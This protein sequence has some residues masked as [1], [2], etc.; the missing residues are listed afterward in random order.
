M[1][2]N[3]GPPQNNNQNNIFTSFSNLSYDSGLHTLQECDDFP[4][5]QI[6]DND[7]QNTNFNLFQTNPPFDLDFNVPPGFDNIQPNN[8][9][10]QNEPQNQHTNSNSQLQKPQDMKKHFQDLQEERKK[11]IN[12]YPTQS[13]HDYFEE[14]KTTNKDEII[15]ETETFYPVFVWRDKS[16][17]TIGISTK[18]QE[19]LKTDKRGQ[20]IKIQIVTKK[21][22]K[23]EEQLWCKFKIK[24]DH[25]M[26]K[27]LKANITGTNSNTNNSLKRKRGNVSTPP[28]KRPAGN[29]SNNCFLFRINIKN[30]EIKD[31]VPLNNG[32]GIC[33]FHEGNIEKIGVINENRVDVYDQELKFERSICKS[34]EGYP[35][36]VSFHDDQFFVTNKNYYSIFNLNPNDLTKDSGH[37]KPYTQIPFQRTIHKK[38]KLHYILL[39]DYFVCNLKNLE[40]PMFIVLFT[41]PQITSKFSDFVMID[42]YSALIVVSGSTTK[43][44][45]QYNI[46]SNNENFST[47]QFREL[48]EPRSFQNF[49]DY[50]CNEHKAVGKLSP[51]AINGGEL[52]TNGLEKPHGI[53]VWKN[54]IL[55]SV[56]NGITFVDKTNFIKSKEIFLSYSPGKLATTE[57]YI[58]TI[59]SPSSMDEN[60]SSREIKDISVDKPKRESC[61]LNP[62]IVRKLFGKSQ[63]DNTFDVRDNI[64]C[65]K[66]LFSSVLITSPFLQHLKEELDDIDNLVLL[67]NDEMVR[68]TLK[69]IFRTKFLSFNWNRMCFWFKVLNLKYIHDHKINAHISMNLQT[70]NKN[71]NFE[72]LGSIVFIDSEWK[73]SYLNKNNENPPFSI[74][75]ICEENEETIHLHHERNDDKN[76]DVTSISIFGCTLVRVFVPTKYKSIDKRGMFV[77]VNSHCT[78][79]DNIGVGEIIS[80]GDLHLRDSDSYHIVGCC[81][82]DDFSNI[83]LCS[84]EEENTLI[85]FPLH[86]NFFVRDNICFVSMVSLPMTKIF[87]NN[88]IPISGITDL[89]NITQPEY[90]PTSV[91]SVLQTLLK[92]LIT[93]LNITWL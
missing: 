89:S 33:S 19:F 54:H 91:D 83:I 16:K 9:N 86:D 34:L 27:C 81:T 8:Q 70:T 60:E 24:S 29:N 66:A 49:D 4:P 31:S 67:L 1:S 82:L 45:L 11:E 37:L 48:M 75:I 92:N 2:H 63:N 85:P 88:F 90:H 10:T 15:V 93:P 59:V 17:L 5:P 36:G 35:F 30:P 32:K 21:N 26:W 20:G 12:E 44:I 84:C 87:L 76:D 55:I 23:N 22:E 41:K 71:K 56:A 7:T 25:L 80:F 50:N 74:G 79:E 14:I 53:C 18:T 64:N 69:E 13:W 68:F 51:V 78:E 61:D 39:E 73:Y 47:L 57:N 3:R 40:D 65:F 28:P 77:I 6:P 58:F 62:P 46:C 42:E 52:F 38:N 43:Q 72:K